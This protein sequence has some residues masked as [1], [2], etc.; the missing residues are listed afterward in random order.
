MRIFFLGKTP[1]SAVQAL[2]PAPMAGDAICYL[3]QAQNLGENDLARLGGKG[4]S[5][6]FA[7]D[8][9]D[10]ENSRQI[11][12]LGSTFLSTWFRDA[13]NDYSCLGKLSLGK[14]YA[15]ELARQSNPRQLIRAGE[16]LRRVIEMHP[17]SA[18][19][20]TDLTNGDSIFAYLPDRFPVRRVLK[21]VADAEGRA[22]DTVRAVKPIPPAM[23]R[24]KQ[25]RWGR[26]A[27]SLVSGLRPRWL[28]ARLALA[29]RRLRKPLAPTLYMFVG[30]SQELVARRLALGGDIH[31][32]T[33]RIGIEGADALRFDHILAL[34]K[35]T[36]IV[37][38]L[39]LLIAVRRRHNGIERHW[40]RYQCSG[41]DYGPI[42]FGAVYRFLRFEIWSFLIILAQSRRLQELTGFSALFVNGGGNEPM[43]TLIA[44]NE[45]TDRK[46]YL[47]PHGMDMQRFA[48][49]TAAT[50]NPH[51][52]NLAY[53]SDH[54]DYFQS[55]AGN[56]NAG[57][58]VLTGNTLTVA[59]EPVRRKDPVGKHG[60]RLLILAFGPL[61][62]WNAA[63]TYACDRYY[64]EIFSLLPALAEKGWTVS[65][66]S[67][68]T[69][70]TDL[71]KLLARDLGVDHLIGWD[72]HRTLQDAIKSCDVVLGNLS[73]ACY[74]TLYAGWPTII[75]EPDYRNT[76]SMEGIE[77][78]P[79]LT[80]LLTA[81][82]LER[83]VTNDPATLRR[84]ILDSLEPASMVSTFPKR[85][86]GE[87]AP[88]FIGPDPEHADAV[89]ADF[90]ERDILGKTETTRKQARQGAA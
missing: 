73:T 33:D 62:F 38:S 52:T 25:N 56:G 28:R 24:G 16:A 18:E 59:M 2:D 45:D 40:Q 68:P 65:L 9:I 29:A 20:L 83:P 15:M 78:D 81:R 70:P 75:Y 5:V 26:I 39:R 79:M 88:R 14:S 85:F 35:F 84:M 54:A 41:I 31:V 6:V 7:D 13:D 36:D 8:L 77:T 61:E 34:P 30:H 47:M 22:F 55:W 53:G 17:E 3:R 60:K 11:D 90:L 66:R 19:V 87:L 43:G 64:A 51:V 63:R 44:L 69:S 32:V 48:Y 4:V 50:D 42:L 12:A 27:K 67:H 82:D 21:H 58:V 80:G 46:T 23:V 76:G 37:G 71:E 57:P 49:L 10:S 89:I 74:Q 72:D 1:L 86:A